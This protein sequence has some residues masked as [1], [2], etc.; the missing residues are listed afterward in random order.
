MADSPG[1]MY[2]KRYYP[3]RL[4]G[5]GVYSREASIQGNTVGR[6]TCRYIHGLC[7]LLYSEHMH[8]RVLQPFTYIQLEQVICVSQMIYHI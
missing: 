5:A 3:R 4:N 8:T 6:Y 7:Q 1:V 2:T